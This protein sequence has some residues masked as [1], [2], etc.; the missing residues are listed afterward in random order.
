MIPHYLYVV[1]FT[2]YPADF[3]VL[4]VEDPFDHCVH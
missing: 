4:Q 3:A 2:G 1:G